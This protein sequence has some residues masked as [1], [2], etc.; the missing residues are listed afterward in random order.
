MN[1]R[2]TSRGS[3][4]TA[5]SLIAYSRSSRLVPRKVCNVDCDIST[6]HDRIVVASVENDCGRCVHRNCHVT[7]SLFDVGALDE[8]R[9]RRGRRGHVCRC[10]V[11]PRSNTP[12]SSPYT[13]YVH[14]VSTAVFEDRRGRKASSRSTPVSATGRVMSGPWTV[15]AVV[16]RSHPSRRVGTLR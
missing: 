13:V 3:F 1:D 15:T 7:N 6:H 8:G 9:R 4:V 12:P 11:R 5:N 10:V 2:H 16:R 14:S